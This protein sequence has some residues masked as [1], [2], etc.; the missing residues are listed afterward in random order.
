MNDAPFTLIAR[1]V[2]EIIPMAELK[3]RLESGKKLKIKF[4]VDPTAPDLHL[5][6][7]VVINKLRHFQDLGHEVIFLIGDFTALIGDPT[8]RNATRPPL[9]EVTIAENA[10][11]YTAQVFKILDQEKTTLAFNSSWMQK[12]SAADLVRLASQETVARMLERDDFHKRYQNNQS[13]AIH[14]FLYPLLQGQDSVELEADVELGGTDQKFN[15]LMGRTLQ[16]QVGQVPQIVMTLPLL[17]GVDGVKKM[18]KSYGNIIAIEAPPQEMF[19]QLM[20][21]SDELMWRYFDLLSFLSN[22]EIAQHK[23]DVSAG[24]NPRDKKIILAKEIV[25]RFHGHVAAEKAHAAFVSQFSQ[26]ALPEDIPEI[27][28]KAPDS[29]GIPIGTLLKE[30]GLTQST[31]EALRLIKQNAVKIAGERVTDPTQKIPAPSSDIFQVG[32]RRFARINVEV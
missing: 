27:T 22:S 21:I 5:G 26:G 9:D 28:L 32:K 11:T 17:E 3:T 19:G 12:K 18:S 14:E 7:T 16:K 25:A 29:T 15:L 20:S 10:A 24:A 2:E 23:K 4:G 1:G 31:G 6:H 13:I 30:A 8:G